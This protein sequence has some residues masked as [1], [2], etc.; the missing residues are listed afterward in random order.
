LGYITLFRLALLP[1]KAISDDD[2]SIGRGGELGIHADKVMKIQ[3]SNGRSNAV[4]AASGVSPKTKPSQ[5]AS[6]VSAGSAA[7]DQVQ[8]SN[9]A[10]LAAASDESAHHLAKM[11]SLS[12]TVSGGRYQVEAGV[13]SNNIIDASIHVSGGNYA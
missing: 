12:A 13:L 1:T 8:L 9:L 6:P 11:S 10:Q 4:G 3:G 5:S 7:T 2:M